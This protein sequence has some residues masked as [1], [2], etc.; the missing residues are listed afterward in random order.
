MESDSFKPQGQQDQIA[1]SV[2]SLVYLDMKVRDR[3]EQAADVL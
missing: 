2:M 3:L 1:G